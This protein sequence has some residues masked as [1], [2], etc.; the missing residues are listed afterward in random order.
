MSIWLVAVVVTFGFVFGAQ[1]APIQLAPLSASGAG[2]PL[3]VAGLLP[4]SPDARVDPNVPGSAFA[5]VVSINMRYIDSLGVR[6]SFICS[7]SAITPF[8]VLTAGHCM[9][10]LDDGVVIDIARAGNDVRVVVND[11]GT[12]TAASDVFRANRVVVHPDFHGIFT[13]PAGLC[14]LNDDLAIISLSTRLPDTLPKYQILGTPVLT[15]AVF[16]MVGY[17]RSGNGIDGFNVDADFFVR[18][19]GANVFDVFDR[20]DEQGYAA[21]SPPEIFGYDFDGVK[22]GVARDNFCEIIGVC[23]AVLPNDVETLSG[24]GDSG[25]PAFIQDG[26]EWLLAGINTFGYHKDYGSDST[27]GDFGDTA[28]GVLLHPYLGWIQANLV[29][30]PAPA[31]HLLLGLGIAGLAACRRKNK[32]PV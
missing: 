24:P 8:H 4:D 32:Q 18:R 27:A 15:G 20:D 14:G 10:P 3:M 11:D 5:G 12:F 26:A 13:C 23:S 2:A 25:G 7:G 21:S 28:G 19:S 30:I 29:V 9:S 31:T 17:G 22:N 6:Q 1:G 16:T